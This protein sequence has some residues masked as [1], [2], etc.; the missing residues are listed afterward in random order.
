MG[1]LAWE[2]AARQENSAEIVIVPGITAA[3]SA[4][5]RLGAPL[6]HDWAC[7]SLSDLLTPWEVITRRVEAAARADFVL[8][9]YN[10]SSRT[11]TRQLAAVAGRLLAFRAR[12]TPVG[13]VENAYRTGER[14][15]IV[16]LSRPG[17]RQGEREHVHDRDCR[18]FADLRGPGED[19]HPADLRGQGRPEAAPRSGA[20]RLPGA[21]RANHGGVVRDHRE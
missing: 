13:L 18:E 5:A 14:V 1:G 9:L 15:E 10:P 21:W 2:L 12:E 6:A 17:A 20:S 7:V 4:A 8:V 11:R 16:S 3:C 19:D